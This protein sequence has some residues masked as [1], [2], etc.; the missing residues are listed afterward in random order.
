MTTIPSSLD[1]I[2]YAGPNLEE[3]VA[4]FERLTGVHGA[5]G[6]QHPTGTEN[7]LVA[8]TVDGERT[9][10]Y[11]ELIGP[12]QG[13]DP[14]TV[15]TFSIDKRTAPGVATF[16]IHPDGVDEVFAQATASGIKLGELRP[17][18]R[19]KPSGESLNWRVTGGEHRDPDPA[20]PFLID[21]S[22][23]PHPALSDLPT[24]ELVS[25]Q[26]SHPN[27]QAIRETYATLGIEV[28]VVEAPEVAISFTA[29]DSAG[30]PVTIG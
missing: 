13:V 16:A 29:L 18:S 19:L 22:D 10:H 7:H 12:Q 9:L 30:N 2:V 21:W 8:F 4:D 23:T 20:V 5:P 27:P 24:I 11:L 3:V 17:L 26:V 1:H 28:D 15:E 25:F 14:A 6:G